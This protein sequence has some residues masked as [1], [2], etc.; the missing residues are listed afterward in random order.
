VISKGNRGRKLEERRKSKGNVGQAVPGGDPGAFYL[1]KK[2]LL[3]EITREWGTVK[4]V[5]QTKEKIRS[6]SGRLKG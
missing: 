2:N 3:G 5:G 1:T 4:K 6:V